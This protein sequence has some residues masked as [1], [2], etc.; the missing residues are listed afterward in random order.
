MGC[1]IAMF[2]YRRVLMGSTCA[3]NNLVEDDNPYTALYSV[4]PIFDADIPSLDMAT[5]LP[6]TIKHGN[7]NHGRFSSMIYPL[8]SVKL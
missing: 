7:G 6:H 1:S 8:N 4:Q 5:R 2:D 3:N